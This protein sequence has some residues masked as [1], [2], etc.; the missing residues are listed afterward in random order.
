MCYFRF[1][2]GLAFGEK[3]IG[4]PAITVY[5]SLTGQGKLWNRKIISERKQTFYGNSL[6]VQR[7]DKES[8]F[9]GSN[10]FL[11]TNTTLFRNSGIYNKPDNKILDNDTKVKWKQENVATKV[12]KR[13]YEDKH[14]RCFQEHWLEKI[15]WLQHDE[16][17]MRCTIYCNFYD[18]SK[19]QQGSWFC[20]F[21][22][23]ILFITSLNLILINN[24]NLSL[25]FS[26]IRTK[27]LF[28]LHVF[29]TFR[30]VE[31]EI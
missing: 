2:P 20:L 15:P 4:H 14:D 21:F 7:T 17:D 9:V 30:E 12:D 31:Y 5:L 28:L 25:C 1:T 18:N 29:L 11:S 22:L 19:Q 16:R 3:D 8:I 6:P 13:K 27:F 26:Q 23:L 10:I 24:C